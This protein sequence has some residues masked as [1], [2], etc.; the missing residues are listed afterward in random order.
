MLN[1]SHLAEHDSAVLD[2]LLGMCPALRH[3]VVQDTSWSMVLH[4][5]AVVPPYRSVGSVGSSVV[6]GRAAICRVP[7]AIISCS[8]QWHGVEL[9]ARVAV[10]SAAT[11][12][13]IQNSVTH[14]QLH[15]SI[16]AK[17]VPRARVC[18]Q[19]LHQVDSE[20]KNTD[21]QTPTYRFHVT[22]H[23]H[24]LYKCMCPVLHCYSSYVS[25]Y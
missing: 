4:C 18:Q 5:T 11:R 12:N 17:Y 7:E 25:G 15:S 6:A 19:L 21:K 24:M 10:V 8:P 2:A 23:A 20:A 14:Q 1:I 13:K 3:T 22:S 9:F 16:V